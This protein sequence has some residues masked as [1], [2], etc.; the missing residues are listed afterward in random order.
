M[1]QHHPT[2]EEYFY[3]IPQMVP[4]VRVF[5]DETIDV[6]IYPEL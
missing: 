3:D 5:L 1:N 2:A 4:N 6:G